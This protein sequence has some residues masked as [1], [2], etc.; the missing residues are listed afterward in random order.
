M[1]GDEATAEGADVFDSS[2]AGREGVAGD[3]EEGAGAT[4]LAG[5]TLSSRFGLDVARCSGAENAC[6]GAGELLRD[7]VSAELLSDGASP[8]VTATT[9]G[10]TGWFGLEARWGSATACTTE[11]RP[12]AAFG[13]GAAE[14]LR[15]PDEP[16]MTSPIA[17]TTAPPIHGMTEI[18][19]TETDDSLV[20][21][22][23]I[24]HLPLTRGEWEWP[25]SAIIL[26]QLRKFVKGFWPPRIPCPGGPRSGIND[27]RRHLTVRAE[28]FT[29][30]CRV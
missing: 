1:P 6:S 2:V 25:P 24:S 30:H 13:G 18:A 29:L 8:A 23:T 22:L 14:P 26:P 12:S 20:G 16:T 11:S 4:A 27:A 7:G 28:P 21:C 17:S 15:C 10:A 5:W 19:R 9:A 3:G